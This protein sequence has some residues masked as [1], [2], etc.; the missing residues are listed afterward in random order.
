MVGTFSI[1]IGK[2]CYPTWVI[3]A[4]NGADHQTHGPQVRH[5][6]CNFQPNACI[7]IEHPRIVCTL[8]LRGRYLY[9]FRIYHNTALIVNLDKEVPDAFDMS[10]NYKLWDS[11]FTNSIN[12]YFDLCI[13]R[14][15]RY[16]NDNIQVDRIWGIIKNQG[17]TTTVLELEDKNDK[18]HKLKFKMSTTSLE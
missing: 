6:C 2:L 1:R 14:R 8:Y 9:I 18:I 11:G 15:T 17:V 5:L 10:K 13:E 3:Q 7:H 12:T 16:S 4:G